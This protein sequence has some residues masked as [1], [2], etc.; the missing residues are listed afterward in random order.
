ME[1]VIA[2]LINNCLYELGRALREI[3]E[4]DLQMIEIM[5]KTLENM[6]R[7]DGGDE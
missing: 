3:H 4:Q 5:E 7:H 2:K 6:K 1:R